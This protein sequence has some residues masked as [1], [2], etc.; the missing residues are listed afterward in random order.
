MVPVTDRG[1]G[2][3]RST[4]CGRIRVSAISRRPRSRPSSSSKA[5]RTPKRRGGSLRYMGPPRP[6][7]SHN[8]PARGK[9]K[10]QSGWSSQVKRGPK[11]QGRSYQL[12]KSSRRAVVPR[13]MIR[14]TIILCLSLPIYFFILSLFTYSEPSTKERFTKGLHRRGKN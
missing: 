12:L 7:P 13:V 14:S 1:E 11:K 8:R 3:D 5:Q 4:R 6:A 10:K 9:R 2:A